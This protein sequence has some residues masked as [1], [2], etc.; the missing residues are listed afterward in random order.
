M[1]GLAARR[2]VEQL[3][4]RPLDELEARRE[5]FRSEIRS[6]FT[7]ALPDTR[8][9]VV[10]IAPAQ[11]TLQAGPVSGFLPADARFY[12]VDLNKKNPLGG[13]DRVMD[14][15][16]SASAASGAR[17]AVTVQL[18]SSPS[19]NRSRPNAFAPSFTAV[20]SI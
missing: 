2:D 5:A 15:M 11:Y 14:E 17:M 1:I 6:L 16:V 10:R 7:A 3:A 4:H 20:L 12:R 19:P 8:T 18:S 9:I 13:F